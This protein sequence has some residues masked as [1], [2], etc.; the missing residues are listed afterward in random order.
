MSKGF[1]IAGIGELVWDIFST[2]KRVGGAPANFAFHC[3][4]LGAEA[5]PVSCVGTDPLGR[6]MVEELKRLGV[7]TR[8]VYESEVYPTGTVTVTLR[9]GKPSYLIGGA[10]AW[11]HIPFPSSLRQAAEKLDAVCFGSL[12]QRSGE[13]RGTIRSFLRQVPDTAL[14]IFDINLRGSFF[15]KRLIEESLHCAN[16]LKLSDEELPELAKFFTLAGTPAEQLTGLRE[17]FDLNLIAYTRGAEGSLLLSATDM[18]DLAGRA[19]E[20]VD[21]VGAG[22]SY[23][24]A[25]CMGLLR[26]WPLAEVNRFASDVS[27]YVCMQPG[28]TPNLPEQFRINVSANAAEIN[29]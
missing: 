1:T 16:V 15:S 11:D 12:S 24:A 23:T 14:K 21:T 18:D 25:L 28:A 7:N 3:G 20:A 13:S 29:K 4:A 27:A 8:Y 22:D 5:W 6:E 19:V 17:C 10:T 9:D 2:H 26:E